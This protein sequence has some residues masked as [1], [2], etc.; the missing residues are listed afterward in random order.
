M[1]AT[2]QFKSVILVGMPSQKIAIPEGRPV[3]DSVRKP[4]APPTRTFGAGRPEEKA[5]PAAR[6]AKY[7]KKVEL[8]D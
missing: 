7:R 5:H 4:T 1:E 6:N 2:W 3:S 8:S